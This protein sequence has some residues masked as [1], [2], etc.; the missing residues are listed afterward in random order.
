MEYS[1]LNKDVAS[2]L[3]QVSYLSGIINVKTFVPL[4]EQN[5]LILDVINGSSGDN[6]Y[7][8][9][10]QLDALLPVFMLFHYTDIEFTEEEKED[11]IAIYNALEPTGLLDVMRELPNYNFLSNSMYKMIDMLYGYQNSAVGILEALTFQASQTD[12]NLT[13]IVE[14][15]SDKENLGLLRD[16][17]TKLG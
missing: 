17:L 9:P 15:L 11:P 13:E 1:K 8:N 4:E 12:S 7:Y 3:K 16:V 14:K 10:V 6:R 5:E 2:G